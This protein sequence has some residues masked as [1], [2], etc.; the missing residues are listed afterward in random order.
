MKTTR[1]SLVCLTIYVS[2]LLTCL[3]LPALSQT[4]K[5]WSKNGGDNGK[6]ADTNN[7]PDLSASIERTLV[8][9]LNR[10]PGPYSSWWDRFTWDIERNGPATSIRN[11]GYPRAFTRAREY[12]REGYGQ[13]GI[14]SD[15]K[16]VF[17]SLFEDSAI[18]AFIGGIDFNRF[19]GRKPIQTFSAKFA[20]GSLDTKESHLQTGTVQPNAVQ[21]TLTW[22]DDVVV[23]GYT[24]YGVNL[25]N[26][27][28]YLFHSMGLWK[29][30]NGVPLL[31]LNSRL[32]ILILSLDHFGATRFDEE[33]IVPLNPHNQLGFGCRIYPTQFYGEKLEPSYSIRFTREID[34]DPSKIFYAS[35]G[36]KGD[37]SLALA[38]ISWSF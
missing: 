8:Y 33:A 16:R 24:K 35:L 7:V 27:K 31:I 28:P 2:L 18:D 23:N 11:L 30:S 3:T 26:D 14:R 29:K 17:E 22:I 10:I 38:G 19:K 34:G 6:D 15:G 25:L 32:R 5:E 9:E 12:Q 4:T 37:E 36:K 13:E 20:Q 21:D 1:G